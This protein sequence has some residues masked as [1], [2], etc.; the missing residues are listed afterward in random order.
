MVN[1][2]LIIIVFCLTILDFIFGRFGFTG[3]V[4][5]ILLTGLLLKREQV[6]E[7]SRFWLI[8]LSIS[9]VLIDAGNTEWIGISLGS[10]LVMYVL[11]T[12][13]TKIAWFESFG[14]KL[15]LLF[16]IIFVVKLLVSF[17]QYAFASQ[18]FRMIIVESLRTTL[19]VMLSMSVTYTI[20][21]HYGWKP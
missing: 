1:V 14:L 9:L 20:V 6:Y 12:L 8:L 15:I 7:T 4:G 19:F 10:V 2:V 17:G 16:I 18:L 13:I 3:L 11:F 5:G 21:K